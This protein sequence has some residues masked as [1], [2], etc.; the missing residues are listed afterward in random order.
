MK[1]V[2]LLSLLVLFIAAMAI[3]CR[4]HERCPAYGHAPKTENPNKANS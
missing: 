3:S 2:I 1:K 4:P